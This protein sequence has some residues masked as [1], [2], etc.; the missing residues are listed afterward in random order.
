M[1][2][3]VDTKMCKKVQR[4][5]IYNISKP[6]INVCQY[7]KRSMNCMDH[8]TEYYPE[9]KRTKLLKNAI[10]WDY[11]KNIILS[12]RSQTRKST[13]CMLAFP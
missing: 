9:V 4:I 11:L 5:L 12:E 2:I 13:W 3:Y 6:E 7:I 8:T 1:K 10:T